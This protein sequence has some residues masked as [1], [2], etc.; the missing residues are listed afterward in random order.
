MEV[1][2]HAAGG[3]QRV[4][5]EPLVR[6]QRPVEHRQQLGQLLLGPRADDRRGDARLV[7]APQE[8]QLA[9]RPAV[10]AGQVGER[11]PN[12]D[13]A[14][15]DA[16]RVDVR[17]AGLAHRARVGR[18]R[19]VRRVPPGQHAL[20]QRGPRQ[21]GE[22]VALGERDQF[23]LDA[24]IQEIVR[25]LLADVAGEPEALAHGERLHHHPGRMGR[26]ADVA[27]LAGAHEIGQR[28][29]RLVDRD[30]GAGPVDLVEVDVVGAEPAQRRV[31]G[32]Q[33]VQARV[34]LIV[35]TEAGPPVDLGAE[36]HLVAAAGQGLPD[37]ALRIA[38]VVDVGGID[39]VDA[40]VQ[41]GVDDPDRV[42]LGRA[43][44]EIHRAEAQ[45][46]H[47]HA[48]P[49]QQSMVHGVLH[50]RPG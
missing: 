26:A 1:R 25:R 23:V 4:A 2:H 14:R 43:S 16:I 44:A 29:E 47:A 11:P 24:P 13:A 21:Q 8:R 32:A 6:G 31:A 20:S 30:L 46:R 40:R 27:D 38:R 50:V 9:R 48:G 5:R 41:R 42:G 36:D 10:R 18:Q 49:A 7:L 22:P 3:H 35:G 33:D 15:R 37:D 34:A 19:A 45:R 28:A 17:L 12:L 39:E